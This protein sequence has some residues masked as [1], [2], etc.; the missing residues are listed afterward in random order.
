MRSFMATVLSILLLA[1]CAADRVEGYQIA[2]HAKHVDLP[3]TPAVLDRHEAASAGCVNVPANFCTRAGRTHNV[4]IAHVV[5][6]TDGD[7]FV[8]RACE[9]RFRLQTIN[10]AEDDEPGYQLHKAALAD[11]IL[12]RDIVIHSTGQAA[13]NR[14]GAVVWRAGTRGLSWRNSVNYALWRRGYADL[15]YAA[16][17][18]VPACLSH[19]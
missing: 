17:Y 4:L 7:T 14:H 3:P 1:G 10:T 6:V 2:P 8:T 19:E 13:R 5:R 12:D 15:R 16:D 18:P 11:W 9:H